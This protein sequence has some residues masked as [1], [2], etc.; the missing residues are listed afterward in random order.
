MTTEVDQPSEQLSDGPSD[1]ELIT[2]VRAGDSQAY[3]TL[4]ARHATA[5]TRL[6][7]TLARDSSEA[8]DLVAE[9]FTRI[10]A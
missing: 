3:A 6:A 10:L 2:A 7:R 1:A 5:A 4:Y 8:D 9:A